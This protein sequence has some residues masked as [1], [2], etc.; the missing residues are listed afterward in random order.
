MFI[1][2]ICR[3]FRQSHCSKTDF[4]QGRRADSARARARI[5]VSRASEPEFFRR[6]RI[7]ELVFSVHGQ[8]REGGEVCVVAK[9]DEQIQDAIVAVGSKIVPAISGIFRARFRAQQALTAPQARGI[10]THVGAHLDNSVEQTLVGFDSEKSKQTK[11]QLATLW[12][13]LLN[14]LGSKIGKVIKNTDSIA[15]DCEHGGN[16]KWQCQSWLSLQWCQW[17]AW[18]I[19]QFSGKCPEQTSGVGRR[20]EKERQRGVCC[21]REETMFPSNRGLHS[22]GNVFIAEGEESVQ[23]SGS[24]IFGKTGPVLLCDTCASIVHLESL[25]L[26]ILIRV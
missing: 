21:Q 22:C 25:L 15:C 13:S 20:I 4:G 23:P 11:W 7:D 19:D 6:W 12:Y 18:W 9:L 5:C 3:F 16:R 2:T 17:K 14:Y 8:S 24:G 10:R 26:S 1:L